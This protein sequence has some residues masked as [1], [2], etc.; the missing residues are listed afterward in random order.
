M[1][2]FLVITTTLILL[3]LTTLVVEAKEISLDDIEPRV[4]N[5]L[6]DHYK[7]LYTGEIEIELDRVSG[8]PFEVEDGEL[9]VKIT[10]N[11]RDRFVQRTIVRVSVYV[12]GK[13]QKA[14]GVP[15]KLS[16]YDRVWVATQHIQRGDA[17]TG[18]NVRAKRRDISKLAG[19]A[20]KVSN[21]LLNTRAR[22]TFRTNDILDHRFI[23]KDPIIIRNALVEVIFKSQTVSVAIPAYAMENGHK[24]DMVRVKSKKF[25][26]EYI[27]KVIDKGIILVN[28]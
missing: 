21:D 26:K 6:V 15:A 13:F 19:T 25:N 2:N 23:E 9:E 24:G 11:L 20:S 18:V 3:T 4:K 7:N 27:G 16:L 17:L 28:I 1:R 8:L 10:S 14:F 22:K 12:D 5:F